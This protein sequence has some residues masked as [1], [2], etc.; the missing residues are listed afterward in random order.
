MG[1]MLNQSKNVIQDR[2]ILALIDKILNSHIDALHAYVHSPFI[3][4][5]PEE[6]RSQITIFLPIIKQLIELTIQR[7]K[8]QNQMLQDSAS[9][10]AQPLEANSHQS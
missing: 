9:I 5:S 7:K 6:L 2:E 4:P 10:P 3:T 8:K 1:S